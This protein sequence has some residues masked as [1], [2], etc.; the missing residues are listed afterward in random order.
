M[1]TLFVGFQCILMVVFPN[2]IIVSQSMSVLENIVE[3]AISIIVHICSIVHLFAD[4]LICDVSKIII[5]VNHKT[6]L[7]LQMQS[8][9]LVDFAFVK[10]PLY[11]IL[12]SF[13]CFNNLQHHYYHLSRFLINFDKLDSQDKGFQTS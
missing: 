5:I 13:G 10:I 1:Y 9:H 8:G 2:N 12:M 11:S 3:I 4:I 7:V 6:F